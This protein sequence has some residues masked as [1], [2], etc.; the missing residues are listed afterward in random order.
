MKID[1]T[2]MVVL[3]VTYYLLLYDILKNLLPLK[4]LTSDSDSMNSTQPYPLVFSGYSRF[5]SDTIQDV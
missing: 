2:K 3:S 4:S 1:K 5:L